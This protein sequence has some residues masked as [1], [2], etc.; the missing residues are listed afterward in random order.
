MCLSAALHGLAP[1]PV[2]Q[3]SCAFIRVGKYHCQARRTKLRHCSVNGTLS[4]IV[5][6]LNPLSLTRR[7]RGPAVSEE[8]L[9][10]G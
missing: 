9:Q 3:T 8:F 5:W 2:H 7:L 10:M 6:D 1:I 4:I